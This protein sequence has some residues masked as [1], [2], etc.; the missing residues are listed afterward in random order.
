M[1]SV[2][3]V[4]VDPDTLEFCLD[5]VNGQTRRIVVAVSEPPDPLVHKYSGD[6]ARPVADKSPTEILATIDAQADRLTLSPDTAALVEWLAERDGVDV[7]KLRAVLAAKMRTQFKIARGVNDP[8]DKAAE[9]AI[10]MDG[11]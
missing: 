3:S 6:P 7:D 9:E 1:G 2:L 10:A 11:K 4:A 8:A 5:G